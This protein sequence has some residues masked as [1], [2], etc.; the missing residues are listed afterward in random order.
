MLNKGPFI[1]Q[2]VQTLSDILGRME[3]HQRKKT[4]LFRRLSS[5]GLDG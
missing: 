3:S 5:V 2:A 4:P 1:P